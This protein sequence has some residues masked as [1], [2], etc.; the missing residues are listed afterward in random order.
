MADVVQH[1]TFP[2]EAVNRVKRRRLG[3]LTGLVDKRSA[4]AQRTMMKAIFGSSLYGRSSAG[5]LA[6]VKSISRNDVSSFHRTFLVPDDAVLGIAGDFDRKELLQSLRVKF[7]NT[8]W[9]EVCES[10]NRCARGCVKEGDFCSSYKREGATPIKNPYPDMQSSKLDSAT[11]ILMDVNDPTLNQAQLRL[12]GPLSLTF[13]SNDWLAYSLG[14]QVLGGDFN[15]RLNQELRV[16]KGLTYGARW[17]IQPDDIAAGAS[18]ATTYTNPKNVIMALTTILDELRKF[19][20]EGAQDAELQRVKLR[21]VNGFVFR[22]E[23]PNQVLDQYMN[24]WQERLPA[25]RLQTYRSRVKAITVE[26]LHEAAVFLPDKHWVAVVV[27][28]RSL[29]APLETFA[30]SV[31]AKFKVVTPNWLGIGN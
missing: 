29:A 1:P 7:G 2:E 20:T 14:V 9:G 19:R 24:L 17:S 31:G 4:L 10:G 25:E 5:T 23:T 3:Q 16:K 28:N 15:A 26:Q 30:K 22:F 12:G 6:S 13:N 11:V 21:L 18:Y 27:A 8:A